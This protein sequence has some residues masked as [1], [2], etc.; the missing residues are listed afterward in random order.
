MMAEL[1]FQ[2]I[3][4]TEHGDCYKTEDAYGESWEVKNVIGSAQAD[5]G[6]MTEF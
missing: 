4:V 5:P 3:G 6:N 2:D 1:T